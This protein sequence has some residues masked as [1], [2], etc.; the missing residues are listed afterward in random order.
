MSEVN[1][2]RRTGALCLSVECEKVLEKK[3]TIFLLLLIANILFVLRL[4]LFRPFTYAE[5]QINL[6]LFIG[7]ADIYKN[8]GTWQFF[9]LFIGNIG[10]FVPFGFMLTALLKKKVFIKVVTLGFTFSFS[11]EM[12]Q[13]VFRKGVAELD[14]L[15]LNVFG[16]VLGYFLYRLLSNASKR[17]PLMS[18]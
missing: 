7:L 4:T 11:I 8:V 13:Y 15:I 17:K 6:R 14:D 9:R 5:R 10:W 18:W 16:A 3:K 1:E 2:H 12:L